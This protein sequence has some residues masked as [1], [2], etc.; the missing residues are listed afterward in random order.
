MT[1]NTDPGGDTS[2]PA[3]PGVS[4]QHRRMLSADDH[5][6]HTDLTLRRG[7]LG[8]Q[9]RTLGFLDQCMES[10]LFDQKFWISS[11]DWDRLGVD[12]SIFDSSTSGGDLYLEQGD[13]AQFEPPFLGSGWSVLSLND[14]ARGTKLKPALEPVIPFYQW[15]LKSCPENVLV[16]SGKPVSNFPFQFARG[17]CVAVAEYCAEGPDEL[18][19]APGDRIVIAGR[20][21][22][23]FDWFLGRAEA[24]GALGLVKTALVQPADNLCE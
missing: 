20:L 2:R 13:V 24:T 7:T 14:G 9:R 10:L 21:V 4:H 6:R 11:L 3:G 12:A 16:G 8:T 5:Q 17:T 19:V 18:S 1:T 23:G 15:F 22:S